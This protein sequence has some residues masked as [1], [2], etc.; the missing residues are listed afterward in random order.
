MS[1]CH[2]LVVCASCARQRSAAWEAP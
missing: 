2:S 1:Q